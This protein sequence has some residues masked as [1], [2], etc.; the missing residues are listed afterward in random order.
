MA[1]AAGGQMR[2]TNMI[3][4]PLQRPTASRASSASQTAPKTYRI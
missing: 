3:P 2:R 1:R 4:P